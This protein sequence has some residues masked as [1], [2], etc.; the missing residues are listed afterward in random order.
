MV[1][2]I[3]SKA[4][5]PITDMVEPLGVLLKYTTHF[6]GTKMHLELGRV[7]GISSIVFQVRSKFRI[8]TLTR[9]QLQKNIFDF[10]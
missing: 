5:E 7:E 1:H 9:S 2:A 6:A 10:C 3:L 8:E 4:G